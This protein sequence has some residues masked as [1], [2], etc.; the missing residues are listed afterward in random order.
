MKRIN[1]IFSCGLMLASFTCPLSADN[2]VVLGHLEMRGYKITIVSET[3]GLRYVLTQ[4]DSG[5]RVAS[6]TAEQLRTQYADVYRKLS[7]AIA[8]ETRPEGS[9]IWAGQ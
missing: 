9:F 3:E 8:N 7:S 5:K 6:V 2:G 4:S 1:F